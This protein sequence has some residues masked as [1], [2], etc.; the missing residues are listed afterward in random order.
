[1]RLRV[2]LLG[3]VGNPQY[4]RRFAPPPEVPVALVELTYDPEGLVRAG[5]LF[6]LAE[7]GIDEPHVRAAMADR[8]HDEDDEARLQAAAGLALLGD[9]RGSDAFRQIAGTVEAGT[10]AAL[11][12]DEV[13]RRLATGGPSAPLRAAT[14]RGLTG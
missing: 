7:G 4:G 10:P 9:P 14:A 13:S 12:V 11:R 3:S 2:A 6:T 1:V 8:L 5:A